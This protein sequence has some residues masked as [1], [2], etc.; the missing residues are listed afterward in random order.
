MRQ[1]ASSGFRL[2]NLAREA[3]LTYSFFGLF[4]LLAL[5]SS[6]LYYEDLVGLGGGGVRAY[7]AGEVAPGGAPVRGAQGG[8]EI[9]LPDEKPREQGPLVVAAT[10]RKLLEVTHFHLFTVPVFLLIITHLFMLT[11]L[12][13]R[14]KVGWIAGGWLSA[15]LHLA[16][17]WLV[18]Y[19]GSGF[20]PL[21]GLSG[22]LLG[23]TCLVLT[24][25]PVWAMWWG[26]PAA[27]GAPA[28]EVST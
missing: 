4:A 19:G 2:W 14:S 17:P 27:E 22:A 8:P 13:T 18:R 25:Y 16:A 21:Y 28:T 3:K 26:R 12:A 11:G 9:A 23:V 7:Y 20:S 10:Y 15:L 1:F 24:A 5:S 6:M